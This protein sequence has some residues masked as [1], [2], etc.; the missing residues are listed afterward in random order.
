MRKYYVY[1]LKS[2]SNPTKTY[3]GMTG[4]LE[5]SVGEHNS[6][7]Q[8]YSKRYAPWELA[9]HVVFNDRSKAKRFEEYLK[10]GLGKAMLRKHFL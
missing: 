1:V 10:T 6:G 5:R 3:V 9:V 8:A 4:D 2:V 7:S